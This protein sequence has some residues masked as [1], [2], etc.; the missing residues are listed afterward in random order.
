MKAKAPEGVAAVI[1]ARVVGLDRS[2]L[3]GSGKIPRPT[4]SATPIATAATTQP[5]RTPRIP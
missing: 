5:A 2:R 4:V 3:A 1:A